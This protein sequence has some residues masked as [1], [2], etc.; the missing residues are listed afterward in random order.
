MTAEQRAR[1]KEAADIAKMERIRA[2]VDEIVGDPRTA[3]ALKPYYAYMCKRPGFH[4]EYL[5]AFNMP[6][7]T[8]VDTDGRGVSRMY[9]EGI[10]AN[11]EKYPL[12][13]LIFATGFEF[14]NSYTRRIGFDVAG[15]AGMTLSEK[16]KNGYLTLHGLATSGFPNMLVQPVP[17][18]QS[19]ITPNI[20][21]IMSVNAGHMAYI[22]SETINRG[23]STFEVT[24]DAE[25][26]WLSTIVSLSLRDRS[27]L[28]TCTPGRWNAEGDPD[29]MPDGNAE[30]GGGPIEFQELLEKWRAAGDLQGLKLQ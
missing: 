10:I 11:G 3:E 15:R 23:A 22:I 25:Q 28:K 19:A 1:T 7:V 29:S 12:D 14:G 4:D 5:Q 17:N 20:T 21:D 27:F 13:C 24:P 2:R 9:S 16:W 30:Y 8:L 6:N 26:A 18:G